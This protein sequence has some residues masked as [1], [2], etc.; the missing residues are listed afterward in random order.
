MVFSVAVFSFGP[1][2]E[3]VLKGSF[4]IFIITLFLEDYI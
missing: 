1:V 4:L 2:A 3:A